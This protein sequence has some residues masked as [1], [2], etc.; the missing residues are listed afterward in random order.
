MVPDRFQPWARKR[1]SPTAHVQLN[2]RT[3]VKRHRI[4]SAGDA[5]S[6]DQNITASQYVVFVCI[7]Q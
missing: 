3:A 1:D 2:L 5:I 7:L 4:H 6:A